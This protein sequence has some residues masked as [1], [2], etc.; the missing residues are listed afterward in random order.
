MN[1]KTTIFKFSTFLSLALTALLVITSAQAQASSK[2]LTVTVLPT[3]GGGI[4]IVDQATGAISICVP[5]GGSFPTYIPTG[6]C[7]QI[8]IVTP[9]TTLPAPSVGLSVYQAQAIS[10]A[11][12]NAGTPIP[13][14]YLWI[15]NNNTGDVNVCEWGSNASM[16]IVGGCADLGI[17]Q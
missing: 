1:C 17:V 3:G 2:N 5:V 12:A 8:G 11:S 4:N 10:S 9:N 7:Q 13:I 16:H 14:S 15:V 6:Y